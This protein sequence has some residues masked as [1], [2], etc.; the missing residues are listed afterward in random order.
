MRIHTKEKKETW[1]AYLWL[2]AHTAKAT[3]LNTV[4]E[5]KH[6]DYF[7]SSDGQLEERKSRQLL[8]GDYFFTATTNTT[9][10][11]HHDHH[12]TISVSLI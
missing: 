11:P 9:T 8:A 7:E 1:F 12:P 6:S 3:V 2:W 5:S 10:T 4:R